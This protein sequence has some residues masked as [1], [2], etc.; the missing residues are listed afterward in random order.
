V[1]GAK[2]LLG[3]L[4]DKGADTAGTAG[5]FR[6]KQGAACPILRS[7]TATDNGGGTTPD[8]VGIA[9]GRQVSVNVVTLT[10]GSA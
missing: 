6:I 8:S 2:T 10:A 4:Q 3:S 9:V 5:P 1:A 7:V